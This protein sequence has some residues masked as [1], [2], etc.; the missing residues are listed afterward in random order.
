MGGKMDAIYFA[1]GDTDVY[2]IGDLPD[3]TSLAAVSMTAGMAG[4][5]KSL[6]SCELLTAEDLDAAVQKTVTYRA[7]GAES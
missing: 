3:A 5:V 4:T 1:L 2:V 7:P 6:S